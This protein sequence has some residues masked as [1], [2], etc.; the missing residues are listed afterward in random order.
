M[1]LCLSF[2]SG[3]GLLRKLLHGKAQ[4]D[5]PYY[6]TAKKWFPYIEY[7]AKQW[8]PGAVFYG[9]PETEINRDGEARKWEYLFDSAEAN[10]QA[11]VILHGGFISLKEENRVVLA[12]VKN[13]QLDSTEALNRANTA[14]GND[15][16]AQ[17]PQ[18]RIF[19]S[20][21][22]ELP[23]SRRKQTAWLVKYQ[24]AASILYVIVDVAKGG[25]IS[26]QLVNYNQ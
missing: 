1:I 8:R 13:W 16:L 25:I 12:S 5:Y 15:F 22:T 26:A 23:N 3:C 20:L 19:L 11:S 21:I 17:N 2:T 24:G 14:A 4:T 9:I 6:C 18:A 7:K 10:K